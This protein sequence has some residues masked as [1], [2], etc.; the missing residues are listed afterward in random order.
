MVIF[1]VTFGRTAGMAYSKMLII[2]VL[3]II[4]REWD[5]NPRILSDLRFSRPVQ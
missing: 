3:S 2:S 4:R 5:S 1:I